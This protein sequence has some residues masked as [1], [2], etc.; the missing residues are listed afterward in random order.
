[1][2]KAV[3]SCNSS[4]TGADV[5]SRS[6]DVFMHFKY[7]SI[8]VVARACHLLKKRSSATRICSPV[9]TVVSILQKVLLD[10]STACLAML[11]ACSVQS[12]LE[13]RDIVMVY[14]YSDYAA[15]IQ[16]AQ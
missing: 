8:C 7:A 3:S 1:M 2:D 16:R 11:D 6:H 4:C 9:A 13:T 10:L 14:L 5:T 15:S 12:L